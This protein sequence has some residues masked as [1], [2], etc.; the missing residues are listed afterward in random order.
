[1]L[2]GR[3]RSEGRIAG[4]GW[5]GVPVEGRSRRFSYVAPLWYEVLKLPPGV[6]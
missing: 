5:G 3:G 4:E 2:L 1:M 6:R